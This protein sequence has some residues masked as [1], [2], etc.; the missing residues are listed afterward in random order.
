MNT[1]VSDNRQKS[2]AELTRAPLDVLVIGGG[3]VGSGVARDAAMRGLRVGLVEQYDFAGGTSSRS[4]RLLH[5]GLRYL[6]QGRI[7]LVREASIEKR[8][9]HSIAPHVSAP[10]PFLFPTYRCSPF[11][12]WALWKL[13]IGV[14]IYDLLCSGRNLGKSSSMN[15]AEL[16]AYLPGLT[17]DGL[18]GAVRY[19]DGLTSDARLVADTLRSAANA[20]GIMLN[21]AKLD[22]SQRVGDRWSCTVSDALG[23]KSYE[24]AARCVVNATG[25]WAQDVKHSSV[26]LRLTKGVHLVVD[27]SRV[28]VP[29]AVVLTEGNRIL[30]AIPWGERVILGTT[31]TDYHG[32]IEDVRAE[33]EDIAYILQIVNN[34]FPEAELTTSDVISHW[35]GLRPLIADPNGKPSDISRA[36]EIRS[37]EPGWWDVAGGKLTTYRLMAEQTVDRLA[38]Q[39]GRSLPACATAT[40]PLLPPEQVEGLSGICPPEL[41]HGAVEHYCRSE[42]AMH[43]DDIM[44]RRGGWHYYHRDSDRIAQQVAGW[45]AEM[46]GWTQERRQEELERYRALTANPK[47]SNTPRA[48][49]ASPAA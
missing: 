27:R 40:T 11:A 2:F 12:Q 24:I 28:P 21:Y 44:L 31:D 43:L 7:G 46:L 13:R 6:A 22:D 9:I 49:M 35:A 3:I 33:A 15:A 42:W 18:T 19:F 23:G 39:L 41:T 8:I 25:P 48:A 16:T 5:G 20:G 45:M 29:D 30:F 26:K 37:P 34:A 14:K 1:A 32:R 36:H 47:R 17:P 10:L 4:S 38:K